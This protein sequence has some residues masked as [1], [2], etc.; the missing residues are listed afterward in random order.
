MFDYL[1]KTL[2]CDTDYKVNETVKQF[3]KLDYQ[4]HETVVLHHYEANGSTRVMF[5][6]KREREW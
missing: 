3:V 2:D 4:L 1:I 6:F 5:I